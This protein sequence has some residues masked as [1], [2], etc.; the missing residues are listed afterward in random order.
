MKK[1]FLGFFAFLLFLL[2]PI[3]SF[4]ILKKEIN[5]FSTY[6]YVDFF[7]DDK[8]EPASFVL[9][10]DIPALA[11]SIIELSFYSPAKNVNQVLAVMS[12]AKGEFIPLKQK[13]ISPVSRR[14]K[15][16][17]I[18]T[19][20]PYDFQVFSSRCRALTLP[21]KADRL[22]FSLNDSFFSNNKGISLNIHI[23]KVLFK[24]KEKTV[25]QVV[26]A[27]KKDLK[28]L[29]DTFDLTQGKPAV[30][31]IV[32]ERLDSSSSSKVFKPLLAING[33]RYKAQCFDPQKGVKSSC[34]FNMSLFDSRG[35]LEQTVILPMGEKQAL[36]Q[37]GSYKIDFGFEGQTCKSQLKNYSFSL[38]IHK[39]RKLQIGF[40]RVEGAKSSSWKKFMQDSLQD[41]KLLKRSFPV[42]D[43]G[44]NIPQ[45]I[46][47]DERLRPDTTG[48][49]NKQ[50]PE[51]SSKEKIITLQEEDFNKSIGLLKDLTNLKKMRI[52]QQ[53]GK[54]FA[55]ADP[56][57][58]N[59]INKPYIAGFVVFTKRGSYTEN[60]GFVR[61]DQ[62]G[63][64]TILHELGHLLGQLTEFYQKRAKDI[65]ANDICHFEGKTDYCFRFKGFKGLYASLKEDYEE[66]G[67]IE[68]EDSIMNNSSNLNEQWIDRDTY[69]KALKTLSDPEKDPEILI[70]S[71]IFNKKEFI[72]PE[73]EYIPEGF[74]TN[75]N[76]EGNL[77]IKIL[78]Q[79][80]KELYGLEIS[81]KVSIEFIDT[82]FSKLS[83]TEPLTPAPV[84]VALPYI[85]KAKNLVIVDK[86]TGKRIY[87]ESLEGHGN[88][89]FSEKPNL[90]KRIV[91]E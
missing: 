53:L 91:Y 68:K 34:D 80:N 66:W 81:T 36:G 19:D 32:Y 76:P 33:K 5:P 9:F 61:I 54:L 38:N 86:Q 55:I 41:F 58:F 72:D 85:E 83:R 12:N 22:L 1:Y 17:G 26:S 71:G 77:I 60:V 28:D 52:K 14:T 59:S 40:T 21:K 62:G 46:F 3:F 25:Y 51:L 10:K 31:R 7:E 44:A 47:L 78:D 18:T 84:A 89:R 82:S 4:S 73:L 43:E 50:E 15:H 90:S 45:W 6:L 75:S 30:L 24:I 48:S 13:V 64:G 67:F 69:G 29:S 88:I 23:D 37:S 79:N 35:L 74:L 70:F 8:A 56:E 42:P 87:S 49:S 57:Y 27:P 65:S 16:S 39:T 2:F 20:I 11:E 63:T